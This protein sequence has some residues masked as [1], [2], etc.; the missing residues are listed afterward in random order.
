MAEPQGEH[1]QIV[2]LSELAGGLAHE[3]R[4][5][6][7]TLKVNLQLLAEDLECARED[8]SMD[9]DIGRRSLQ[10]L[11]TLRTETDRLHNLLDDFLNLVSQQEIKT[12]PQD[13][14][15]VVKHLVAF[16][17]PQTQQQSIHL[18]AECA[19]Q[20]LVCEL[21]VP[22]I[23]QALLN[24]CRNAQQAMPEGG[25]L[26]IETRAEGAWARVDLTD[27]GVGI[28]AAVFQKLF[29]PF[30]STKKGGSGLGLSL[31]RRI[32]LQHGGTIAVEST[33]G[34]GTCF[35]VRIPLARGAAA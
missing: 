29:H 2:E 32:V 19:P 25:D 1:N 7:S 14:N 33:P 35:S 24:L 18:R 15:H 11:T 13:L 26:I 30:F 12:Q 17:E 16:L 20:P 8:G 4:N 31:T 5:P 9:P 6:L 27:S 10:R 21:D 34:Q 28:E 22:L 3:I 23:G